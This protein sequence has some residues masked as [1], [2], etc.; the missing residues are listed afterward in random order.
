LGMLGTHS[1]IFW[2]GDV[3]WNI[4]NI[5]TYFKFSTSEFTK[6]CHFGISKQKHFR[7]GALPH[8]SF[9]RPRWGGEHSLPHPNPFVASSSQPS[10]RVDAT[11]YGKSLAIKRPHGMWIIVQSMN[12]LFTEKAVIRGSMMTWMYKI[13]SETEIRRHQD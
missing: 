9:L 13:V 2:L 4:P 10:I 12:E 1:P 7:G 11:V 3:N 6:I 8:C 5:I